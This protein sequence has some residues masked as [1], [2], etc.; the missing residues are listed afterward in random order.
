[1][2]NLLDRPRDAP[3]RTAFGVAFLAWIFIV[4][5][6]GAA[7]RIFVLWGLSYN[8]QLLAFRIGVWVIPALLFVLTRRLCRELQAADRVEE[9][10]NEAEDEAQQDHAELAG[11]LPE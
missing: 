4:F 7:D 9:E 11:P 5:A 1:V 10:Q 2:H 6:F 8:G 3:N